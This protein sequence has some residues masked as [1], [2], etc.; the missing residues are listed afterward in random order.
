MVHYNVKCGRDFNQ[1]VTE[2]DDDKDTLAVLGIMI[3][4]GPENPKFDHILDGNFAAK[5]A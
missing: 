2:C 5:V 4:E 3:E 1:A